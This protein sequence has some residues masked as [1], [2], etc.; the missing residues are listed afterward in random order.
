MPITTVSVTGP[1]LDSNGQP[2]QDVTILFTPGAVLGDEGEGATLANSPVT[3]TPDAVGAFAVGLAPGGGTPYTATLVMPGDIRDTKIDLGRFFVPE[4]GPVALQELLDEYIPPSPPVPTVT[5]FNQAI[6]DVSALAVTTEEYKDDAEAAAAASAAFAAG[7]AGSATAAGASELAAAASAS[8]AAT[9]E[10]NTAASEAAAS[11]S[12]TTATT[13]AA[14]ALASE[15]AAGGSQSAAAASATAAGNSAASASS[16]AAAAASSAGDAQTSE[17]NAATSAAAS[18]SA[19]AASAT[20]AAQSLTSANNAESSESAAATSQASSSASAS[21]AATSADVASAAATEAEGYRDELAGLTVSASAL[22]EDQD[23]TVS[24][25]SD[26]GE[27]AFGIPRIEPRDFASR[28][29]A[30]IWANENTPAIG[31]V[32]RAGG[33]EWEFRTYALDVI[34]DMPGW[35]PLGVLTPYHWAE[36][37]VPG[38]TDM[39]AAFNVALHYVKS[40]HPSNNRGGGAVYFW[41]QN[42]ITNIGVHGKC[43]T[44][45]G[46]GRGSSQLLVTSLTGDAVKFGDSNEEGS[47]NLEI[48]DCSIVVPQGTNRTS[49]AHLAFENVSG[50]G[51]ENVDFNGFFGGVL[52]K[53]SA[54]LYLDRG[55]FRGRGRSDT[56]YAPKAAYFLKTEYDPITD[57]GCPGI[58]VSEIDG[59]NNNNAE[60]GWCESAILIESADGV[61]IDK[62]HATRCDWGVTINCPDDAIFLGEVIIDEFYMDQA[63]HGNCRI[64]GN[65]DREIRSVTITNGIMRVA[66]GSPERP[67]NSDATSFL[68]DVGED[69]LQNLTVSNVEITGAQGRAILMT[70]NN[71]HCARFSDIT[72][73]NNNIGNNDGFAEV[74]LGGSGTSLTNCDFIGGH[75]TGTTC[76][77]VIS[78]ATDVQI[79]GN[80]THLSR[81]AST[82]IDNGT[83]TRYDT[84][85]QLEVNDATAHRLMKV[86]AFGLGGDAIGTGD[87]DAITANGFYRNIGSGATGA[88]TAMSNWRVHHMQ[89]NDDIAVQIA[90]RNGVLMQRD[91]AGGAWGSWEYPNQV[92]LQ[93]DAVDAGDIVNK[94]NA[95]LTRMKVAGIMA[96]S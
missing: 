3:V 67:E 4:A 51:Y 89:V 26:T 33:I 77:E 84:G 15:T 55:W 52:V 9:S 68:I 95:L 72:I 48:K 12:A 96:S 79:S 58:H 83:R 32:I 88:P 38:V 18:T 49:G 34:S 64:T 71:V 86:G 93:P 1:I 22:P 73:E 25:D 2:Y 54:H 23:P 8:G 27:M 69:G 5:Q 44:L 41:D 59:V 19:A 45:S 37:T 50:G 57:R 47:Q 20:S 42:A 80:R 90:W 43:V 87:F 31:F 36:N 11:A 35:R 28:A 30:V 53:G 75:Q 61:Y 17:D 66:G 60:F 82:L 85:P 76:I 14:G 74:T 94:F 46:N 39:T 92:T 91:K 62:F 6:A 70:N 21:A 16:Y 40:D 7:A 81:C 78:G 29:D 10:A 13:A 56:P 63:F 65:S 24:Y